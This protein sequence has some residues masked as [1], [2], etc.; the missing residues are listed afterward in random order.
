MFSQNQYMFFML[1]CTVSQALNSPS[2]T[3]I[4]LIYLTYLIVLLIPKPIDIAYTERLKNKT[5]APNY[6]K[7][8]LY[9]CYRDGI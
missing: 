6:I 2:L 1:I 7:F 3:S 8:R 9:W 4:L 5:N